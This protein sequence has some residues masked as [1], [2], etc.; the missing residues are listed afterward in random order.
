MSTK[1]TL[2]LWVVLVM[3]SCST[4]NKNPETD[5]GVQAE[6]QKSKT[7]KP[8]E[9]SYLYQG[10]ATEDSSELLSTPVYILL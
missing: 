7:A 10:W 6:D 2:S 8:L 5:I 4:N 3:V 1:S 9:K